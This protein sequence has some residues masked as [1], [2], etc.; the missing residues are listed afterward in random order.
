M[1]DSGSICL[2]NMETN[3]CRT[4][5]TLLLSSSPGG[6]GCSGDNLLTHIMFWLC[7][8]CSQR[9]RYKPEKYLMER[10]QN[11][12]LVDLSS[13]GSSLLRDEGHET[14]CSRLT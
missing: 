8:L 6:N 13:D 14:I 3:V 2:V 1:A 7:F 10:L 11:V 5:M 4:D 12:V 9:H